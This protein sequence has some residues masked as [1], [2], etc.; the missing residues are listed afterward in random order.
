MERRADRYDWIPSC[1]E[2]ALSTSS[3]RCLPRHLDVAGG[4]GDIALKHIKV[5]EKAYGASF[6]SLEKKQEEER[7]EESQLDARFRSTS[8]DLRH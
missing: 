8:S 5:M 1:P 4:T 2:A 3:L 7:I 6:I